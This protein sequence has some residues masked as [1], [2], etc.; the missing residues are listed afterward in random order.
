FVVKLDAQGGSRSHGVPFAP[1]SRFVFHDLLLGGNKVLFVQHF[2]TEVGFDLAV[3]VGII[4]L[5][6]LEIGLRIELVQKEIGFA[7]AQFYRRS[8]DHGIKFI[9]LVPVLI[10]LQFGGEVRD[11]QH[12]AVYQSQVTELRIGGREF[13][14]GQDTCSLWT[15]NVVIVVAKQ[16]HRKVI[17]LHGR[18]V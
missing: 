9:N 12:Y 4:L 11:L 17:G 5:G 6:L 13:Q 10:R 16:V 8:S 7:D 2:G 18:Q 3:H 1:G 15:V 14:L